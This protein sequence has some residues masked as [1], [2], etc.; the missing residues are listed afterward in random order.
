MD[1]IGTKNLVE[2]YKHVLLAYMSTCVYAYSTCIYRLIIAKS[3]F[4]WFHIGFNQRMASTWEDPSKVEVLMRLQGLRKVYS[5]HIC[6]Q[7]I[8]LQFFWCV[9]ICFFV[10]IVSMSTFLL[11]PQLYMFIYFIC[12]Q[13]FTSQ[14]FFCVH[15]FSHIQVVKIY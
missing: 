15:V 9:L 3:E 5:Q 8:N 14:F 10:D 7:I 13:T 4:R 1:M 2:G 11:N 12:P 6:P